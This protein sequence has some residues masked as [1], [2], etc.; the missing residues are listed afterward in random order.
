MLEDATG[1]AGAAVWFFLAAVLGVVALAAVNAERFYGSAAA[2]AACMD[3]AQAVPQALLFI[4][5][6]AIPVTLIHELGHAL[7]ERWLLGTPVSVAVGSYGRLGEL[8]LAKISVTLNALGSPARVA[9][10]ATLDASRARAL[11]ILLIALAGPAA[12]FVACSSALRCLAQS[13]ATGLVHDII[14]ASTLGRAFTV[15]ATASASA[16]DE[17]SR[18]LVTQA[19]AGGPPCAGLSTVGKQPS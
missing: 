9:G 15:S 13:P 4:A 19:Q 8:E 11:D 18:G 10:S 3:S 2:F 17:R 6:G 7:A 14:W 12:S 5:L 1:G 16:A